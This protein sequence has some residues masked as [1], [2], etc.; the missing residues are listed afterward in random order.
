MNRTQT[1]QIHVGSVAI[2]IAELRNLYGTGHGKGGNHKGLTVRHARLA[3]SA[4]AALCMFLFE[5]YE[6]RV[7]EVRDTV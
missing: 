3:V 6:T 7:P 1:K 5:T 4:S 2:G